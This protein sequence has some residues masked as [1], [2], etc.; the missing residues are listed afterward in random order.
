MRSLGIFLLAFV[1]HAIVIVVD[2]IIFGGDTIMRLLHRNDFLM[3]HQ[4][5]MLQ[6]LISGVT[7][8]SPDPLLVRYLMALIGAVATVGFYWMVRDML[9]E[10]WAVGGAIFFMSN[11]F[12]LA[13]STV[14]YQEILML[15]GLV[16]AFHFFYTENWIAASLCLAIACLTRYEA[17]AAC[18]VLALAYV[19]RKD[20]TPLGWLKAAALFG[21]M[22]VAWILA[23]RGA[24]TSPGHFVV[25]SSLSIARLQRYPYLAWVAARS[26]Q[27]T[28]VFMAAVGAFRLYKNRSLIDWRLQLQV[29]FV[30]LFL[31]AIPFSAHGVMPDPER[32]ITTREAHIPICFV[33][34]LAT[35]GL[36]QWP[37]WATTI[38]AIS[39]AL[40]VV[41]A[42][43]IAQIQTSTPDFQLPYR[44]AK[45]LDGAV[46]DHERVLVLARPVPEDVANVYFEKVRR[47]GGEQ[48]LR[49]AQLELKTSDLKPANY[50]RLVAYSRLGSDRLLTPPATCGEWVVVWSDYPEAARELADAQ[51]VEVLQSGPMSVT[52]L[53]RRCE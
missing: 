20:R 34:L 13:L 32:Y 29:A 45:Y 41:G 48:G 52:V 1:L 40:G 8:I 35:L 16:F 46:K 23:N 49:R 3:G 33:V 38:V 5:P 25:E 51:P 27:I 12:F 39:A 31:L 30:I 43:H 36:A 37:R 2:P 21:W 26:T 9:G 50:E 11:P 4:L 44:L 18:P 15:A 10:R 47:T 42:I 17:W 14:P 28:V 19:W 22:P 53:R 6:V 7:R 24:L